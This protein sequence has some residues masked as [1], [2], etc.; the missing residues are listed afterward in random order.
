MLSI[1]GEREKRSPRIRSD[2]ES[3]SGHALPMNMMNTDRSATLLAT[4]SLFLLLMAV[5]V[6]VRNQVFGGVSPH[7]LLPLSVL[8]VVISGALYRVPYDLDARANGYVL[9]GVAL[10][11]GCYA[12]LNYPS[13]SL[14]DG[15][16]TAHAVARYMAFASAVMALWRPAFALLPILYTTWRKAVDIESTGIDVSPTDY[17]PVL[18]V[19][20]ILLVAFLSIRLVQIVRVLEPGQKSTLYLWTLIA[21][22]GAHF[23]NYFY[24]GVAKLLLDGGASSWV[25]EN[26]T[27][28][29]MLAS[30]QAGFLPIAAWPAFAQGV[31]EVVQDHVVVINTLVLAGQLLSVLFIAKPA[32]IIALTVFYDLMHLT[33]YALSGIFFWKWIILNLL[34]IGAV[35]KL[36][37]QRFDLPTK[38]IGVSF[39]L[40]G[41]MFFFTARLGWYDTASLKDI[42]VEAVD[43]RGRVFRVPSN[44]YL[45]SSLTF[46]QGRLLPYWDGHFSGVDSLGSTKSYSQMKRLGRCDPELVPRERALDFS[47]LEGFV[48]RH[49]EWGIHHADASGL[50]HYDRFPHHVWSNPWLFE[51]FA[52]LDKREVAGFRVVVESKCLTWKDGRLSQQVVSRDQSS[53]V[54][55]NGQ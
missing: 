30:W 25:L 38:V 22:I 49:H 26:N 32:L 24:S 50:V 7:S 4:A 16:P 28:N 39:T 43:K 54:N 21:A 34:I 41:W 35:S 29:I 51:E 40:I 1:T 27:A 13:Y 44:Y 36:P 31:S 14:P 18:E 2:A 9:R 42:Y 46:T 12:V 47:S 19:G 23:G 11:L 6:V 8:T 3:H 52:Q 33:I 5:T 45:N 37:L 15:L 20:W 55:T 17:M 10:M 48:L 53:G